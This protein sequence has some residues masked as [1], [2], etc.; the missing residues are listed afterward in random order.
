VKIAGIGCPDLLLDFLQKKIVLGG[1]GDGSGELITAEGAASGDLRLLIGELGE[2]GKRRE[3]I[4]I[5]V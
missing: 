4:C 1:G 2:V 5:G 3:A